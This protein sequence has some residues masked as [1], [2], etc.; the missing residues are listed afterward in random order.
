MGANGNA[1]A[2][3]RLDLFVVD[4]LATFLPGRSESDAAT[5]L[6]GLAPLHQLA[7][8]GVAVLLLHHPRKQTSEPGQSARGSGALLGFVDIVLELARY[9]KLSTDACRRQ[10][11]SLSRKLATPERL[12]FEWDAATGAFAPLTDLRT[13]Q[14]EDNWQGVRRILE[15]RSEPS[16]HLELLND[17]PDDDRDRPS[18]RVLYD[19]LRRAYDED[20]VRR[21]GHGTKLDP[22]R[23]RLPTANDAYY[24]RGEVPPLPPL[25]DIRISRSTKKK[26]PKAG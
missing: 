5:L 11:V 19:W 21:E 12:A 15:E 16:T 24:D 17:W 10:I 2:R 9:S 7:A 23:Y 8:A 4:P 26:P 6:E 20:R 14:F 3:T 25:A 13:R 22:Y 1:T 18:A